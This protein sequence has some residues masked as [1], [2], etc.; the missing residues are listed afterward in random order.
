MIRVLRERTLS[1]LVFAPLVFSIFY[2]GGWYF[3]AFLAL[4][5]FLAGVE[6]RKLLGAAGVA[7]DPMFAAVC[8]AV[9]FSTYLR[10]SFSLVTA[11]AGGVL[12]VLS[13]SLWRGNFPSAMFALSGMMYIGG[14]LGCLALLRT[15]E[16]GRAWALIVL[17]AT[18]ATDVGAYL[19][20]MAFGRHKLAPSIS[21]GKSWEGAVSGVCLSLVVGV[22]ASRYFEIP[23]WFGAFSGL[24]LSVLA[25]LGD[26][27]ESRLKRWAQ[28]KD[29]GN[30]M[31]GHGGVLDRFDSLLFTGAGGLILRV[32]YG[33]I[34][35]S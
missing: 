21:P 19:G 6:Y 22:V 15:G 20:G 5:A 31:P 16:D 29:S 4:V 17:V 11:L 3:L 1:S 27:V 10:G 14:L 34:M 13:L 7:L 23:L 26:L 18:W 30:V 32:L 28:V 2:F 8:A 25:E 33:M 35:A 24:V 12:I 9:V